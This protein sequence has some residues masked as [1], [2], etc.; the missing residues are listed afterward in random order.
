MDFWWNQYLHLPFVEK[1]RDERGVDCWGLVRIIYRQ[2]LGIH[3]PSYLECYE[4]TNDRDDL[5]KVIKAESSAKWLNPKRGEER[6][7]DVIILNMRGLPMHV[8]IVTVPGRMIH[9]AKDI[10]TTHERYDS[11]RWSNKVKG[12]SRYATGAA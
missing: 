1:G 2:Q 11:M 6:P 12:F 3:L 10:N 7:F 9:C 5:A 8:G 4:T